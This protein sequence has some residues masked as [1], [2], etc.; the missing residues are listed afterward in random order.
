MATRWDTSWVILRH[1][2]T[3]WSPGS[4]LTCKWGNV[5]PSELKDWLQ[6]PQLAVTEGLLWHHA[7][8]SFH[9]APLDIINTT[10][11]VSVHAFFCKHVCPPTVSAGTWAAPSR[12]HTVW[13]QK[14]WGKAA[15]S[16]Q[17]SDLLLWVCVSMQLFFESWILQLYSLVL[18]Q[19]WSYLKK[20]RSFFFSFEA[21]K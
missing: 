8:P 5:H 10:T 12:F 1:F 2:L 7:P 13:F 4:L 16:P 20:N 9:T 6:T 19:K 21:E 15:A 11:K 18:S 17:P 3:Q 14:G